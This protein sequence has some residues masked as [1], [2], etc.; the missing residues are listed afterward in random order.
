M[1]SD[2]FLTFLFFIF[3][4]IYIYIYIYILSKLYEFINLSQDNNSSF[5]FFYFNA[6]VALVFFFMLL[7][8]KKYHGQATHL[9]YIWER[10]LHR[11]PLNLK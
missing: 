11:V 5:G 6:C 7:H 8:E 10:G 2:C 9:G 3:Y 4:F 1:N